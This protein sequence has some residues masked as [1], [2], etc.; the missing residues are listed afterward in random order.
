MSEV[1]YAFYNYGI[2][3]QICKEV[4]LW[5]NDLK[6]SLPEGKHIILQLLSLRTNPQG[7]RTEG[8]LPAGLR[9]KTSIFAP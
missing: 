6:K 1:A 5:L 2:R 3:F 4:F 7:L 9:N 8:D